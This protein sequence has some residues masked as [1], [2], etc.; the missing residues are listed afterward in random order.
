MKKTTF[1]IFSGLYPKFPAKTGFLQVP[2]HLFPSV[3]KVTHARGSGS[4]FYLK[5]YKLFV[6]NH[7]VV[8]G[9]RQV[10]IEDHLRHRYLAHVILTN[11]SL[12]IALLD[13]EGYFS[14]LPDL[15]LA[16]KEARTG[17]KIF[18]AGFPFGIPFTITEGT[19]SSPLQ[20]ID[21]HYRIQTDAAV[22]PGNSGGAMFN[23]KG[24]I[25]AITSSK[26]TNADNMGFGIPVRFLLPMLKKYAQNDLQ[27]LH[28]Q[29]SCCD[30]IISEDE[31]Y[32]PHCGNKLPFYL[33]NDRQ[34]S[35]LAIYCEEAIEAMGISPILA[36]TGYES[37]TF[38]KNKSEIRIFIYRQ[39]FLICTSPINLLP[40]KNFAPLLHYLLSSTDFSCYQ[41]GLEDN[42]IFLSY[43]VHLTDIQADSEHSIQK[44]ITEFAS[45]A[46]RT[47]QYLFEKFGCSFPEYTRK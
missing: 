44:N 37:W 31:T 33:F 32:C 14:S 29:C 46:D 39:Q 40:K 10:A 6:T 24:E 15:P 26:F 22:N 35:D 28:I 45:Q 25:V 34:L 2:H 9:F 11:P 12:D 4:C 20:F 13:A 18:V 36:R 27:K 43:R 21:G 23:A 17:D 5:K 3:F 7:H 8:E 16:A 41:L 19:V 30:M 1:P 42:Q 47:A 38:H